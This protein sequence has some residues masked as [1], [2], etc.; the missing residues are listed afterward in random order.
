MPRGGDGDIVIVGADQLAAVAKRLED[1]GERGKGLR[2]EL[3]KQI[4]IAAKPLVQDVRNSAIDTL[5]ARGGLNRQIRKG[6]GIRTRAAG[7]SVGVRIVAK[8]RYAIKSMD[9]GRLRHPVFGNRDVWVAQS[10]PAGWF[11]RPVE[12]GADDARKGALRAINDIA[13]KVEGH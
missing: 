1:A 12:A 7:K 2:K 5:P 8:N 4:R 9:K 11:T 10:V 3:L 6:V 13:R